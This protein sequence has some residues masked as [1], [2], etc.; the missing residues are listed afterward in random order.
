MKFAEAKAAPDR[1]SR[2]GMRSRDESK[3]AARTETP[4]TRVAGNGKMTMTQ[5]RDDDNN[6]VRE[7]EIGVNGQIMDS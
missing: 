6:R 2:R 1:R 5:E 3:L 7:R 4:L